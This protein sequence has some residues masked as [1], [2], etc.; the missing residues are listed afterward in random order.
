MRSH[1]RSSLAIGGIALFASV[2]VIGSALRWT[3]AVVAVLVALALALQ[4]GSRRRIDRASPLVVLLG[5][6]AGLTLIQ[7]IPLPDAVLGAL[8]PHGNELRSDGAALAGIAPWRSISLDPAGTLH[9]LAVLVI[10]LGVAL[11]GHRITSSERGRYYV[12]AGVALCCG[13]AAGVTGVHALLN[14]SN[15]YGVYGPQHATPPILGPLL[16][17]N[18]LGGLMAIGVA[19]ALGLVFYPRQASQLRVLWLVIA[20][21]CSATAMASLSRGATLA[22][23]IGIATTTVLLIVG[24]TGAASRDSLGPRRALINDVPITIV[25][26]FGLAAAIYTTAGKV[27]DQLDNTSL[28]ELGQPLSK[29]A[30]W[31]SSLQLVEDAPWVGIG[32]GAI[33]PVFTRVHEPS[34]YITFSHLENEYIQAV[35][36]WGIP[37]AIALA[38]ALAWCISSAVKRW[39]SGPLAAAAIGA[40]TAIAFQSSVDFGVE[41]LGIAVPVVLVATSLLSGPLREARSRKVRWGRAGLLAA[42]AGAAVVLILPITRGI[43]EDHDWISGHRDAGPGDLRDILQRHPLDYLGYGEAAAA[44]VRAGDPRAAKFLNHALRLHPTHPGLHRLAARLLIAS[45][46]R[47]QA[48]VEYA[49]ALHGTLAPKNLIVEIAALLPEVDLTAAAIPSDVNNRT[50]ILRALH[51]LGRDDVAER[52]LQRLVQGTQHDIAVIDALY[53]LALQRRDLPVAEQAARRRLVESHTNTSRIMLARV[54]F[55]REQFDQVVKDLADVPKWKG[56][57]DEQADAWLLVCDAHI[58]ER[59][60]DAALEC[61]HKLDGSGV[62]PNPRRGDITKRLTIVNEQR[63]TEAKQKAIEAMQRALRSPTKSP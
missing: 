48:A 55:R 28:A 58:E 33:E 45:G 42:L 41:L 22:L 37:G 36:E 3:Q 31:K 60:W 1:D 43:Q 21:G 4:F 30:A 49:L 27:A 26:A 17:P 18:H 32:R 14:A 51:E 10:L 61:L 6:A 63:T 25:V 29:Y 54:M 9:A 35:V 8:D 15:L 34:A 7:L 13:L 50:K 24:R 12:I 2:L 52:W 11:L 16:N 59:A 53:G 23:G 38:L 19:L 57:L 46:R 62:I 40:C 44:L 20:V 56:R 39:R 47:S 5:I